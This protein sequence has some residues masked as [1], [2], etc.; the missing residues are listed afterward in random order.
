MRA[1]ATAIVAALLVLVA[2]PV[3]RAQAQTI[4][5]LPQLTRKVDPT[6]PPRALAD[7]VEATVVLDVDIA[8]DGTV[9]T[10]TVV[11]TDV[12][13][14][15]GTPVESHTGQE[16]DSYG[17]AQAAI[18]AGAQLE[19]S[20]A[21]S[22]GAPIAVRIQ[23]TYRF[24]LPAPPIQPPRLDNLVTKP[25]PG[26]TGPPPVPI[27]NLRGVLVERGTR[28]PVAGATITVYRGEGEAAEGYDATTDA[29]GEFRFYDLAPG[30]WN[31]L[32]QRG[33]YIKF[34][35]RE[36]ITAD[37]MLDVKYYI[38]KGSYNPYDV[39]VEVEPPRKEVNRRTLNTADISKVPGTLGDPVLVIENLPGVAR[40]Q[41][42]QIVVR[43]SGPQDTGVFIDGAIVPLIYHFGGLKSVLP[44][45]VVDSVDFYPGN[46]SVEYG[47][48]MGG[49]FDLH[50]KR[51]EPERVHG[52]ADISVLD[53]SLYLEAP[54]GKHGAVAVAGRRSYIGSVLDAVI[55][56]DSGIGLISA[57][58][59]YDFQVLGNWRP[60]PSQDVRLLFLG[61]DDLFE[62]LFE[63][64][65]EQSG[66]V[67]NSGS[68]TAKTSF[69]RLMAEYRYTP[70][71]E[72][73]N[74]LKLSVGRDRLFF[75][76]LDIF[77]L[78]ITQY[79]FQLRDTASVQI[80]RNVRLNAGVDSL[81][82]AYH[83]EVLAPQPPREG[84]PQGQFNPD[85][86]RFSQFDDSAFAI[87][88]FVE[89]ELTLGPVSLVPGLRMDYFSLTN[90]FSVDPRIVARWDV[91]KFA[92]KAGAAVVHQE[93]QFAEVDV[94]FGNPDLGLQKAYQYSVGGEWR[95]LRQLGL[96]LT[97][98]Y[99]DMRDL[100]SP[101]DRFV[102][103][104]GMQVPERY[105]N[106]GT[107]T[108]YG[109]EVF[110]EH[111]FANNFRGWL[112][113]TL[114]R[115][116]RRDNPDS[117][118]RLF[119]YDQTHILAVVASYVLPRNW[120]LGLRW[121]IVSGSPTTPVI[122]SVFVNERDEYVPLYGQTNSG[123]LPTFQQ[124]DLR[125]D[126]TWVFDTW[127]LGGYISLLNA[128][129]YDNV[130]QLTYNFDYSQKG[131]VKGLPIIP[132]LGVKGEW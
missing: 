43:G 128:Y 72:L 52:S 103:R 38:E 120:E 29:S 117:D 97:L 4:D 22:A 57:P 21:E 68:L 90:E 60:D 121:R 40:T 125:V 69:Q 67:A 56:A 118:E 119:D 20:P 9:D 96:D 106:R 65:S 77:K 31:V 6:Y 122:G 18:V 12:R 32:A 37:E 47:R 75:S 66:T 8:D 11:S 50:I 36:T 15:D 126:K 1:A 116:K 10:V 71:R 85:D 101:S 44:A 130:E 92:A 87:A 34:E 27:V 100:V 23:Y 54:V 111:K 76:A 104:N 78:D 114:S 24:R 28:A 59:Y 58:R 45:S 129:N 48:G 2:A 5:T 109:A 86:I 39:T 17:F 88:P 14:E 110:A 105:D 131:S 115:D 127:K 51:L 80:N 124:L 46:Y 113:Y 7:R 73:S 81:A 49:V 102:E 64:P 89:G 61:S 30:R 41:P 53:T 91:G 79:L 94:V 82:V 83:G 93:P 70:T 95:P 3:A 33:G 132:I 16:Q 35:T 107:G 13:A 108:V 62:L 99:K 98:F 19:F 26:L 74:R 25:P 63:D 55:P 112:S 84:Q 42:G 123:R